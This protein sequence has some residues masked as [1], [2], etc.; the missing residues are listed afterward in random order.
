MFGMLGAVPVFL[1]GWLGW[2]QVAQAGS[3]RRA[4]GRAPL[5]LGPEAADAQRRAKELLP[6]PRGTILDRNGAVLAVDCEVYEVRADVKLRPGVQDAASFATVID[7]LA[8]AFADAL[9]QGEPARDHQRLRLRE[10]ETLLARLRRAFLGS[11]AKDPTSA[12][13]TTTLAAMLPEQRERN[14]LVGTRIKSLAAIEALRELRADQHEGTGVWLHFQR[15]FDRVYPDREV[16]WGIVGLEEAKM[17]PL[18]QHEGLQ[19]FVRVGTFGLESLGAVTSGDA[20]ER[21]FLHD[22]MRNRYWD[23]APQPPETPRV[24]R[25][26]I[27]LELQKFACAELDRQVRT[28]AAEGKNKYADWAALV[29]VDV[30]NGDVLAMASFNGDENLGASSF[31]PYQQRYEP[32]SVVKPLVL[33]WALEKNGLDWDKVYDCTSAPPHNTRTIDGRAFHDDHACGQLTPHGIIVN[34]SNIGAVQIGSQM[35]RQL[36]AGYLD[37]YQFGSKPVLG[38]RQE[39]LGRRATDFRSVVPDSQFRRYSAS[40]LS[41]GYELHVTAVQLARAYL[42]LLSGRQRGLRLARSVEI[43]GVTHDAPPA[44]EGRQELSSATIEAVGAA[45]Q[46]VVSDDDHATGRFVHKAMLKEEGLD[47]HGLIAGKSGTAVS[48]TTKGKDRVKVEVRNASFVAYAPANAPRYL[49][50]CILQKE[51]NARFYGGSYAAPPVARLLLH[52]LRTEESRRLRQE[53]PVSVSPGESGW[54]GNAPE[55]GQGGR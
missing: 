12:M 2:L 25:A 32:G 8:G 55:T 47:V 42:S 24:L 50:V 34:S 19:Q 15:G 11:E 14:V 31:A 26:T 5:A 13:C 33:A 30:A 46:D 6:A 44:P 17:V 51:G 18:P 10:R 38:L 28:P 9:V 43:D 54:S 3:L 7:S 1:A 27:D 22:A 23:S 4:D 53:P 41:I 45:M 16:T 39:T 40:S 35:G 52:A 37:F 36:W 48:T 29:L 49:A 20:G 21:T